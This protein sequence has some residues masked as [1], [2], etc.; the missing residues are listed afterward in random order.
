MNNCKIDLQSVSL[1]SCTDII[2]EITC[3]RFL[4]NH[5]IKTYCMFF[6]HC[7]NTILYTSHRTILYLL[8]DDIYWILLDQHKSQYTTLRRQSDCPLRRL[9][10]Q[11]NNLLHNYQNMSVKLGTFYRKYIVFDL[12]PPYQ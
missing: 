11:N 10:N 6:F 1:V 5:C 2:E 8:L 9:A 3:S 12:H 4:S 7:E